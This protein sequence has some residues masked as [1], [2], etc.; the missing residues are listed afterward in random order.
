VE[1]KSASTKSG[2]GQNRA[3]LNAGHG[4]LSETKKTQ[5]G[6]ASAKAEASSLT[7]PSLN[8]GGFDVGA[9]SSAQSSEKFDFS[10]A[11]I[12]FDDSKA[13]RNS[14]DVS[15]PTFDFNDLSN[16]Q[17]MS[18]FNEHL[19]SEAFDDAAFSFNNS[20]TEEDLSNKG[21]TASSTGSFN[22]APDSN[23]GFTFFPWDAVPQQ[24]ESKDDT[25]SYLINQ[26]S[27]ECDVC[28][29]LNS[30]NLA[31]CQ[32]CK[33]ARPLMPEKQEP[34]KSLIEPSEKKRETRA[35]GKP[36]PFSGFTFSKEADEHDLVKLLERAKLQSYKEKL[37][38]VV[39]GLSQL[40][41]ATPEKWA[42]IAKEAGLKPGHRHKLN[43]MIRT[44]MEREQ[45]WAK[46]HKPPTD[47]EKAAS[48][49]FEKGASN[50]FFEMTEVADE[51]LVDWDNDGS[52]P[53]DDDICF[54]LCA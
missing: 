19:S 38:E 13:P 17:S 42:E 49:R 26:D 24:N 23:N 43:L 25:F 39:T 20:N 22:F 21:A 44:D 14:D 34:T 47:V 28:L 18:A 35:G 5:P 30:K 37:L 52:F 3:Q 32:A 4:V 50:D 51:E 29:L 2:L 10:G 12:A 16:G 53:P 9:K 7:N 54:D 15:Q 8:L 11:Q 31:Q 36:K 1:G 33:S 46:Q 41:G 48:K 40:K 45:K 27:W 6:T